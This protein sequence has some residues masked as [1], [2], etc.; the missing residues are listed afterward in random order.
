MIFVENAFHLTKRQSVAKI[1]IQVLRGG[2][3]FSLF[4]GQQRCIDKVVCNFKS[5]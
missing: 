5:Y 1:E 3:Q 4:K 2:S